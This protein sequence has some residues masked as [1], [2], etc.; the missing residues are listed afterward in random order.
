MEEEVETETEAAAETDTEQTAQ[1]G[2]TEEQ[3]RAVEEY[4]NQYRGGQAASGNTLGLPSVSDPDKAYANMTREDYMNYVRDYRDFEN[5]LIEK[6]KTDTSLID[7]A[8]EDAETASALTQGIAE[9]NRSRYGVTLT[10][11]QMAEQNRAIE[12]ASTLGADQSV[13]TARVAQKA[14]NE[15]VINNL[16]NIGQGVNRSSLQAMGSSAANAAQLKN[17]YKSAKAQSKA[18][19]FSAIGSLGA[20]A[21]FALTL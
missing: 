18:Q 16:I 8:R 17:A 3:R 21:I 12:R 19:T 15:D 1:D 13:N 4:T 6:A 14:A 2:M 20:A 7:Q 5:K 9:R 11:A 10:P